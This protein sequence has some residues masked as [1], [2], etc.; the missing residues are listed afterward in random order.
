MDHACL[1]NHAAA[2]IIPEAHEAI[3]PFLEGEFGNPSS[4]HPGGPDRGGGG[5]RP[6]S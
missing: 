5:G 2:S 4:L 6:T 3:L 1:D